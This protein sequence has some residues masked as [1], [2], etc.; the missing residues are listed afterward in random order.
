MSAF[1]ANTWI[2][3]WPF[4]FLT[5]HS[6][7]TLMAH[8]RERGIDRAVVSPLDAVFAPEPGAANRA[9]LRSTR[10]FPELVPVP[11]I[12]PV[13]ANWRDELEVCTRD[14]RVRLV[15]VLPSYHGISLG[16]RPMAELV[17]ELRQRGVRLAIQVR[18]IDERH[19]HHA[20]RIKPVS[21][22]DLSRLLAAHPEGPLLVSGLLRSE[23][24]TLAPQHAHLL[25]DLS[26]AEW[27]DTVQH[28]LAKV[29]L[30]QLVFASHTP[31]LVT[32]AANAKIVS[33]GLKGSRL[34]SLSHRN[35]E[36]FLQP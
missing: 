16:S 28:L 14:Q 3:R 18:L 26:F 34:A 19:E 4:A 30:E 17:L 32:A 33:S 29:R 2:G 13:L 23:V 8:L 35:L 7:R 24:I 1:D 22:R 10:L 9:L 5:E 31:F 21:M 25:A 36:R 6:P 11:V 20:L 27:H 12:N 15:R